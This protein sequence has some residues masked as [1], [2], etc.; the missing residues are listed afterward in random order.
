[1]IDDDRTYYGRNRFVIGGGR[2]RVGSGSK[3]VG[4]RPPPIIARASSLQKGKMQNTP[5]TPKQELKIASTAHDNN[6][7]SHTLFAFSK[8]RVTP[9]LTPLEPAPPFLEKR[10]FTGERATRGHSGFE[11]GVYR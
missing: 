3:Q 11:E 9:R 7:S 10:A 4:P 8:T 2:I 5:K 6:Y 1:V